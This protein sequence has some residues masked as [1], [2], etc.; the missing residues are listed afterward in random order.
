MKKLVIML[1]T[2]IKLILIVAVALAIIV[3]IVYALFKP[4][5]IVTLGDEFIGYT[6]NKRKLQK[7]INEYVEKGEKENVAFVQMDVL[8]QYKMCLLKDGINKNDEEI[9]NKVKSMG[10][11]YYKYY[12]I[13]KD[14]E[15][16]LYV[17]SKEEAEDAINKLNEKQGEYVQ[18]FG[19]IEK[20]AVDT[21]EFTDVENVVATL[22][23][24]PPKQEEVYVASAYEEDYSY[25]GN[26]YSPSYYDDANYEG[27]GLSVGLIRPISGTI[28]S[29]FGYREEGYHKGLDIAAPTGTSIAAC[30]GGV[31]TFSGWQGDYGN[32]IIIS[33][34]DGIETYYAHCNDL[35][36]SA[37]EQV[38][39]GEIIGA[40]G[41]TGYSTGSHVHLE[42]RIDGVPN[43]PQNYVY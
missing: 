13:T 18:N 40:V 33:H 27:P 17:N 34:G 10:T 29:R 38:A 7:Q 22:Y 28:T 41:S 25:G 6:S 23:V 43:N 24:E 9:L 19:L 31:V 26:Y 21:K 2:S 3:G 37:G 32:L 42:V 11:V 5:Y 16:K 20:I 4:T 39:Q 30:A 36:V 15:E 8:P 35:Y 12:A 14:N 1:R